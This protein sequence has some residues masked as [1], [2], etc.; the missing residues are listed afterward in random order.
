MFGSYVSLSKLHVHNYTYMYILYIPNSE[1]VV[2][3]QL[4]ENEDRTTNKGSEH[5]FQM[6]EDTT[7]GILDL[8]NLPG[9]FF[10]CEKCLQCITECIMRF[11]TNQIAE[12]HNVI[13][14]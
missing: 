7:L 4:L 9:L 12:I 10:F 13:E 8:D 1:G 5:V 2:G 11:M 6:Q 3:P 14:H